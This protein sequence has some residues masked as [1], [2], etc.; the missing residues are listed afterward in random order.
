[1]TQNYDSVKGLNVITDSEL[2][3]LDD[4]LFSDVVPEVAMTIDMIDGF[5]TAVLIGPVNVFPSSWLPL[6]WDLTGGGEEPKFESVEQEERITNLLMKMVDRIIMQLLYTDY[7]EPLPDMLHTE[8][9]E[10]RDDANKLW[11][12][13]FLTG[14]DCNNLEWESIYADKDASLLLSLIFMFIVDDPLPIPTQKLRAVWKGIPEC[15][16]GIGAFWH[17]NLRQKLTKAKGRPI[18]A[19]AGRTGR[20]EACPCG[21]GKKFKKCCGL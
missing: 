17:P 8:S 1:M 6:I 21:S 12:T 18:E 2:A 7:F 3:E 13:G 14:V 5:L 20:N 11:A 19:E 15:V 10:D 9:E 16:S 4:F